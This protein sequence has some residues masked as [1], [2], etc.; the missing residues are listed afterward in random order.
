MPG[1]TRICMRG[2]RAWRY[3][4]PGATAGTGSG[5]RG[6]TSHVNECS[7]IH[8]E[9]KSHEISENTP[10]LLTWP[11]D[12]KRI[13]FCEDFPPWFRPSTDHGMFLY[14]RSRSSIFLPFYGLATS[15]LQAGN[16]LVHVVAGDAVNKPA[17]LSATKRQW[18]SMQGALPTPCDR[19]GREQPFADHDELPLVQRPGRCCV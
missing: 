9:R 10:K 12:R 7:C 19:K 6:F 3:R 15:L 16:I 18:F 13:P 11:P 2:P 4:S 5:S 8:V 14:Q 17:P 1:H